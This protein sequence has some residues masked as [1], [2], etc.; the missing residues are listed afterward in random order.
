VYAEFEWDDYLDNTPQPLEAVNL[1]L[2]R[3][4]RWYA[5]RLRTHPGTSGEVILME[6][7]LKRLGQARKETNLAPEMKRTGRCAEQKKNRPRKVGFT[8]DSP[9]PK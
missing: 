2:D 4:G 1:C 3:R 7:G 6:E 5:R 9:L 8:I